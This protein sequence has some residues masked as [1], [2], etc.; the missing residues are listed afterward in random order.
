MAASFLPEP[1]SQR[2]PCAAE[3]KHIDCGV[4]RRMAA[5]VCSYCSR[6]IGYETRFY[7]AENISDGILVHADCYED[8]IDAIEAT[9]VTVPEKE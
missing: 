9:R 4:T 1:G 6:P 3:C 5:E 2:G 8:A 7:N